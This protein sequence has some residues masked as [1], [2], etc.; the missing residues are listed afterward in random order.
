MNKITITKFK[1]KKNGGIYVSSHR[2]PF[3]I[4]KAHSVDINVECDNGNRITFSIWNDE[5]GVWT[6]YYHHTN[7]IVSSK[8]TKYD[9]YEV[10]NCGSDV[11][12]FH[13]RKE[14]K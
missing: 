6:K 10:L 11:S 5:F 12:I 4:G 3:N 8:N 13:N 2:K 1:E 7:D 14:G 9:D